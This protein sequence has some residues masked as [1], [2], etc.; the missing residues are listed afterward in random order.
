M[1]IIIIAIVAIT[2]S[3]TEAEWTKNEPELGKIHD[4]RPNKRMTNTTDTVNQ[5]TKKVLNIFSIFSSG[6][7]N[8]IIIV[9]NICL[10]RYFVYKYKVEMKVGRTGE[11][12]TEIFHKHSSNNEA[13]KTTPRTINE[14]PP[15]PKR[16]RKSTN[17]I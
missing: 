3:K 13:A 11:G 16:S 7:V 10:I 1:K 9:I 4:C 12:R 5:I 15:T 17:D 14:G 8:F 6:T 2:F